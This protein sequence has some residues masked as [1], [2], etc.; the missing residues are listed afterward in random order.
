MPCT[1]W[2]LGVLLTVS[3]LTSTASPPAYLL[4]Q[5]GIRWLVEDQQAT[6]FS[7]REIGPAGRGAF[8]NPT[9][10]RWLVGQHGRYRLVSPEGSSRHFVA[11][12]EINRLQF[13]SP[14]P[15]RVEAKR[16]TGTNNQTIAA[17][18]L[19]LLLSHEHG[20][21]ESC[22]SACEP[23]SAPSDFLAGPSIAGAITIDI[24]P[25]NCSSFF[26]EF[27]DI[28]RGALIE[29]ALADT[30]HYALTE[31]TVRSFPIVDFI[32]QGEARV[33]RSRDLASDSY[34]SDG[35]FYDRLMRDGRDVADG[36]LAPLANDGFIE[37]QEEGR[38]TRL[39]ADPPIKVVLEIVVQHGMASQ[40]QIE[41]M[42]LAATDLAQQWD[43]ELRIIEIP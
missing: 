13:L 19:A 32:G 12:L 23:E 7:W 29:T 17:S 11:G 10:G 6:A 20:P 42:R 38:V 30:E 14:L 40:S 37:R 43:I 8:Y 1:R 36:L 15:T 26:T 16:P 27:V 33:V 4:S 31:A 41:Q 39:D 3:S 2:L 22:P 5:D 28:D 34:T 25:S 24:R 9:D 35:A 21:V 18:P